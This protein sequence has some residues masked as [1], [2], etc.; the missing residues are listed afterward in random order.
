[1]AA[2]DNSIQNFAFNE[3]L[4]RVVAHDDE[5]WF[6]GVDVCRALELSKP[7][8]AL[9]SLDDDEKYT[10]SE[11]V[12]GDGAGR[13]ARL[14]V[15]E[16]GVFRLVFRSRKPEAEK[17]K[18]WL[19]HEV[20]PQI[21]R[22]G[23]YTPEESRPGM[24][25]AIRLDLTRDAPLAARVDVV[26]LARALFGKDRA[27]SLWTEVGLPPV[28]MASDWDH[29]GEAVQVMSRIIDHQIDGRPVRQLIMD[30]VD[31]DEAARLALLHF[32]I[33]PMEEE[34]G[35]YISNTAQ[36]V[37][38]LFVGSIWQAGEWRT[39]LRRLRGARPH[40]KVRFGPGGH[41]ARATWFPLE[42]LDDYCGTP[43]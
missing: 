42:V 1:M 3:H 37:R 8:N 10:L 16:P 28:P 6:V 21:R 34:D 17:F 40:T 43:H 18:R 35:F 14:V 15:S 31:G 7:E 25:E 38:S 2:A 29:S 30:A 27:R 24:N 32:G 20:L 23:K 4:V 13:A 33:R 36:G 12:I 5:P 41:E 9:A 39:I 22:T 11:G 26:R 19:A